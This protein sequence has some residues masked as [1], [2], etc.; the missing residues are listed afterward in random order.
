LILKILLTILGGAY[1]ISPFDAFPG[2]IPILGQADDFV[3]LSAMLYYLW[4]INLPRWLMHALSG[5][6]RGS[7]GGS[8][9]SRQYQQY[10]RYQQQAGGGAGEESFQSSGRKTMSPHEVLGLR[11]GASQ[12]EIREAYRRLSQQY[13]PDKVSHLGDEFQELAQKKFVEIQQAYEALKR[14]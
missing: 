10:Q 6:M 2:M 4:N 12:E 14:D 8:S 1:I 3:V 7:G 5:F 13:H 11:P 9:R